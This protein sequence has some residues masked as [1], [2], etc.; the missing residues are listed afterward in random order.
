M[1]DDFEEKP[2]QIYRIS[3]QRKLQTL[4]PNS[5]KLRIV[6]YQQRID[7]IRDL[8]DDLGA[9]SAGYSWRLNS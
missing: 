3:P 7:F 2:E 9:V 6:M 5:S 1:R 4:I 8:F